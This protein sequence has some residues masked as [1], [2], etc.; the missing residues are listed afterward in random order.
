MT[1]PNQRVI[2][3]QNTP[4]I[5]WRIETDY[6]LYDFKNSLL[7]ILQWMHI[8]LFVRLPNVSRTFFFFFKSR[9]SECRQVI[10]VLKYLLK[11]LSFLIIWIIVRLFII[12]KLVVQSGSFSKFIDFKHSFCSSRCDLVHYWFI[13]AYKYKD[14]SVSDLRRKVSLQLT[15]WPREGSLYPTP[16]ASPTQSSFLFS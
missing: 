3:S 5:L 11:E 2:P 1:S 10:W 8:W 16:T 15:R 6:L 4:W 13:N 14:L 9:I 7:V 12:Y